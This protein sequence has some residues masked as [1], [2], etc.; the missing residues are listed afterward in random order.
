MIAGGPLL[1]N[2]KIMFKNFPL[3]K[4]VNSHAIISRI[5]DSNAKNK[6][7]GCFVKLHVMIQCIVS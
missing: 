1:K 6:K 3:V 5:M 4:Q 2:S 7:C